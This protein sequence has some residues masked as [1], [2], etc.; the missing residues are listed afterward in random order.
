MPTKEPE[1]EGNKT[2]DEKMA[3]Q[4]REDP[5][6]TDRLAEKAKATPTAPAK[7]PWWKLWG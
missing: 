6:K 4:P 1:D 7:K 5:E 3:D 2:P